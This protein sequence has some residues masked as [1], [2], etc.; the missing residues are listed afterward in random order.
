MNEQVL[1]NRQF[2]R[3]KLWGIEI[4]REMSQ[5]ISKIGFSETEIDGIPEFG[6][7][8]FTLIKD[9]Y[10]ADENLAGYWYGKDKRRVGNIQFL[11][12][13]SFYAEY[14]IVKPHPTKKQWFVEA[15]S[16][17]GKRGHIKTEAKL[18]P[19]LT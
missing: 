10:T 13:G 2:D 12:D 16:A 6:K 4:C 8:E 11:S 14:D 9:P 1:L 17:W 15:I 3:H 19:S 18:L 5:A 7:A